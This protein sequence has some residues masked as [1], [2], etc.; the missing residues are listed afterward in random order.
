MYPRNRRFR[1]LTAKSCHI[2]IIRYIFNTNQF[3]TFIV[4]YHDDSIVTPPSLSLSS[5]LIS[6]DLTVSK[7]SKLPEYTGAVFRGWLGTV[8]RCERAECR[9]DCPDAD[10]CP[11]RMVFKEDGADIRPYSILSFCHNGGVRGF[12][13]VHG[14]RRQFVPEMLS[15]INMHENARHFVK[16]SYQI[17]GITAKSVEILPLS[18]GDTTTVSFVTPV[19]LVRNGCMEVMPSFASL[20]KASVR[21][22]NRVTKYFDSQHYPCRVPDE[23]LLVDVPILDF[24]LETTTVTHRNRQ[25]KELQFEGITGWMTFDTSGVNP[26]LG[27]VLKAG[28]YLQIGKNTTYGFGGFHVT[29]ENI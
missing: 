18:L 12:V 29:T 15:R 16:K 14:D 22:F 5:S 17:S 13:K 23:L 8:M 24:S 9:S 25:R 20:L 3:D 6:V 1:F 4:F 2:G 10:R 19:H 7:K 21:S 26:E 28:E 27:T 11:Y